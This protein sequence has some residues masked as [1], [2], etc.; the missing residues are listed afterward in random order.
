MLSARSRVRLA[1]VGEQ[2]A[3]A[4]V[5]LKAFNPDQ[6]RAEDGKWT[7]GG[8]DKSK[9]G[10]IGGHAEMR[11]P[12]EV[13]QRLRAQVGAKFA[14][15]IQEALPPGTNLTMSKWRSGTD[16]ATL[17]ATI[18]MDQD[19]ASS[20]NAVI[21]M[22]HAGNLTLQ[23]HDIGIAEKFRGSGVGGKMVAAL[24][25]GF[26]ALGAK[27]GEV[28]IH[29]NSNRPFWEHMGRKHGGIYNQE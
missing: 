21:W 10:A 15:A 23:Q 20:A 4:Q 27:K 7:D 12:A 26:K 1:K 6:P 29:V 24:A 22:D 25:T 9:P 19:R 8:G 2:L 18:R 14:T 17:A 13:R 16:A 5:L 28:F 11:M 3:S